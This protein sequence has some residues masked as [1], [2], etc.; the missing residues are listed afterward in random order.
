LSLPKCYG[1]GGTNPRIP[2]SMRGGL[3]RFERR[4]GGLA[5]AEGLRA[6]LPRRLLYL[7]FTVIVFWRIAVFWCAP[8]VV[9]RTCYHCHL[10]G[11]G[12]MRKHRAVV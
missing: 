8:A 3:R 4:W 5:R 1:T 9:C 11:S 10:W 2:A 6:R 7:V 12:S